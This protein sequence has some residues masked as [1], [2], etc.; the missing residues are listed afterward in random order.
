MGDWKDIG[1]NIIKLEGF[2]LYITLIDDKLYQCEIIPKSGH[3]KLDADMCIDWE[4]MLDPPNQEF[5]NLVNR[6]YELSLTMN[7]FNKPMRI[8]DIKSHM[9]VQKEIKNGRKDVGD[10]KKSN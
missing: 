8:R 1:S 5:L 4:E 9:Q 10:S 3:P 6:R 2:G 7:S